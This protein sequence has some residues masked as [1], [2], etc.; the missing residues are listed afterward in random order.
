MAKFNNID[1]VPRRN[2]PSTE[3]KV[4]LDLQY[5]A[6]GSY[7]DP[8]LVSAVSIFKDTTASSV[9]FPYITNGLPEPLLDLDA[10][11][12][13][14]GLLDPSSDSYIVYNFKNSPTSALREVSAFDG[15]Q[16]TASS[17]FRSVSGST[18]KFSVILTPG[19]SSLNLSGGTIAIPTSGLQSGWYWD[20]WTIK[21]T[22]TGQVKTYIQKFYLN[23]NNVITLD[24]SFIIVPS[25]KMSPEKVNYGEKVKLH[26]VNEITIANR[27]IPTSIKNIFHDSVIQEASVKIQKI[28]DER[29]LSSHYTVVDFSSTSGL[30]EIT[31]TDDVLYMFD[32][33]T[34]QA[35]SNS[36]SNLFGSVYGMY[37]VQL[38]FVILE[39]TYYSNKFYLRVSP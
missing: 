2:R 29:H 22:S 34:L 35:L 37:E 11:S 25:T 8:Y 26:F 27:N 32:T 24:E 14:Y 4:K 23:L 31:S 38:K 18:G 13:N 28:N 5:I 16:A 3:D 6:N 19:I 1:V 15:T 7:A 33:T 17:I 39:E 10:S 9:Q 20:I 12:T 21:H 30:V 36:S